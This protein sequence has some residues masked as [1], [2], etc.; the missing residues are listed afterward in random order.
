MDNSSVY[1]MTC[2]QLT[3]IF[4]DKLKIRKFFKL[5][6]KKTRE[7]EWITTWIPGDLLSIDGKI[8]SF[9]KSKISKSAWKKTR[10][11]E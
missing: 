10:E 8:T 1:V 6:V 9:D 5:S 7:I 3:E 2:C 4:F 11:I